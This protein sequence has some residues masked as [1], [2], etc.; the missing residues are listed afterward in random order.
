MQK[1]RGIYTLVAV[2][3]FQVALAYAGD[4]D[5]RPEPRPIPIPQEP[6][7]PP[8]DLPSI[9]EAPEPS[10]GEQ[11]NPIFP[12][13]PQQLPK[14]KEKKNLDYHVDYSELL[15]LVVAGDSGQGVLAPALGFRGYRHN[16]VALAV[17]DRTPGYGAYVEYNWNRLGM[18]TYYSYRKLSDY[19]QVSKSQSFYGWYLLY[20]WLPFDVS[21]YF[22]MGLEIGTETFESVG[23]TA[24]I[25]IEANIYSGWTALFGYTYHSTVRKGFL[26]GAFGWS[27]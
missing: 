18:G 2:L 22:G 26:G 7:A 27:F 19:D 11:E 3:L 20:R 14:P 5:Q 24:S 21:P 17:G 8:L 4:E 25:G 16:T 12:L 15:E 1:R 23:G 6:E 10:V 9:P 13:P